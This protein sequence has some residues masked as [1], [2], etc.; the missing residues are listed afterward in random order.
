M[1]AKAGAPS[2]GRWG[3][4]PALE[5]R[6]AEGVI[7]DLESRLRRTLLGEVGVDM[8]A[9]AW[10]ERLGALRP[11]LAP[12]ASVIVD[13]LRGLGAL[14]G[15]PR[16][17]CI[18]QAMRRLAALRSA[19]G[20][21]SPAAA[22]AAATNGSTSLRQTGQ[23]PSSLGYAA[24]TRARVDQP[25]A[26]LGPPNS[27]PRA[28]TAGAA[29]PAIGAAN[30]R[31][32]PSGG[33]VDGA[34]TLPGSKHAVA[35]RA[36]PT[37]AR[38]E[39]KPA[40]AKGPRATGRARK[41][42]APLG[43]LTLRSPIEQVP[44]YTRKYG[45]P[46]EKL[47]LKVIGDLLGHYPRRHL[48]YSK[49]LPIAQLR[50][51]V[52]VTIEASVLRC[53]GVGPYGKRG[54]RIEA[55][56]TDSTGTI[57]AVWFGQEWRLKQL[58]PGMHLYISGKVEAF[59]GRLQFSHPDYE[60]VS[61]KESV[62]TGRLVPV[63][64]LSGD[65]PMNWLRA[66]AKWAVDELAHTV[67]DPLPD[68]IRERW[69]LPPLY[70]ALQQMHFPDD[71]DEL[72]VARRRIAFDDL[73]VL[74]LGL[75]RQKREWQGMEAVSL[76][77]P[78]G[79]LEELVG[80]L[81][82]QLTSAQSKAVEEILGD[83]AQERPM[84]RLLQGDVGSGKTVVAAL[85]M[86]AAVECGCQAAIVAP[87]EILAEQHAQILG[88]LFEGMHLLL[89]P[90]LIT[91]SMSAKARAEAW[92]LVGSGQA[93]V[94]VGTHALF[95]HVGTFARLALVVIDEQHRFGVYQRD[96][97]WK[98]GQRPHLLAMTAT[99][100]PRTLALQKYGDLDLSVINALPAGRKEI[101]TRYAAPERREAV[102][103][104]VRAQVEAGRQA[105]V[106][107]PWVG[108]D[109][110][111]AEPEEAEA[112]T[113]K[114]VMAEYKRLREGVFDG[115]EVDVL[116]GRLKPAAK[117]AVMRRF[118]D[119]ETKVLVATT[120][121]EVGVDVPNA[122]AILIE[123]AE[124]FGLAQLH[125]LR[126]RVGRGSHQSYCILMASEGVDEEGEQR[127]RVVEGTN[128]GFALAEA[129]L[130]LRRSGTFFGAEQSGEEQ[131][132]R[133]AA[134]ADPAEARQAAEALLDA[135]PELQ[136]PEHAM[137]AARVGMLFQR[138]TV[139]RDVATA[140]EE[141]ASLAYV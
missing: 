19:A 53:E 69:K 43:S 5:A 135:D 122:T 137:L 29:A 14:T 40:P 121:I 136:A 139:E 89:K 22:A 90:V 84:G 61:E 8:A 82:F 70:A 35:K 49:L 117:D 63:Y 56:L 104:F 7:R 127:L 51:G 92:T 107:C 97:L 39:A 6:D 4:G 34:A 60:Q 134:F 31:R 45:A 74:Q 68:S 80:A 129:D 88:D 10:V 95:S 71:E 76:R 77:F 55:T 73:L 46:L 118:R 11:D 100:I 1:A 12:E 20:E 120:V 115:L 130:R 66:K 23:M 108:E 47:K 124:R 38:S 25:T 111:D 18:A 2:A 93:R 79:R 141:A 131:L 91:G 128:D 103:A 36:E 101:K 42:V 125:Q 86:L 21:Q 123:G 138:A 57:R 9:P 126:G 78:R 113:V 140:E 13:S 87:T 96:A 67:P 64:R 72:A 58:Q 99:P 33:A 116:H 37:P 16:S 133:W 27:V 28:T 109:D 41:S 105:Y 15:R 112:A 98:K 81:P 83:I 59:S 110:E 75:L 30:G 50:P 17:D 62:H 106:I 26:R 65:L 48:D 94:V 3:P 24:G 54:R 132:L 102:Y 44:G 52:E 119:G 32:S 85:A 114:T